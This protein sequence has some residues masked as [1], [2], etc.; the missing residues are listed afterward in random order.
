MLLVWCPGAFA[1]DPSLDISQYAHKAWTIREG[2]FKGL[3]SSVAQ[4]PDG[5]FWLGTD[6]GVFRFDGVKTAAFELPPNQQLPSNAIW[7]LLAD[8]DGTLWIGTAKGLASWKGGKLIRY[9]ELD[10]L[11]VNLLYQDREGAVWASGLGPRG[12]LCRIQTDN[13]Q[14]SGEDGSLGHGVFGLFEDSK[15]DFWTSVVNGVWHWKPGPPQFHP[16]PGSIDSIHSFSESQDSSLLIGTGNGIQRLV[17]GKPSSYPI[18]GFSGNLDVIT[19]LRDRDGGFW[20]GT[21]N[22]LVHVHQG[23]TDVFK[24]SDGLSDDFV[25]GL[26]EDREGNIWVN[27]NGGLDRFRGLTVSTFSVKQGLSNTIVQSVLGGRDGGVWLSTND[28][29]NHWNDGKTTVYRKRAP[30]LRARVAQPLARE[31]LDDGLPDNSIE[32]IFQDDRGRLWVSTL[33]GVAYLEDGRFIPV[34]GVPGGNLPHIIEER[35]GSLWIENQDQGLFHLLDGKVVEQIPWARFGHQDQA[36]ALVSDRARGGLWL[37][38][39][40]GGIAYFADGQLRTSYGTADGLGQGRITHLRL[41]GDGTLWASTG[42]GLSRLKNGSIRTLASTN[43]LPCDTVHWSIEDDARSLWLYMPC[44]LVRIA[45]PELAAWT[46][47]VDKENNANLKI[48]ASVF[49]STDGIRMTTNPGGYAPMVTKSTDGKL[50][51][52]G[53]DGVSVLDPMHLPSTAFHRRC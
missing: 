19:L 47:A 26:F 31:I 43:G 46:A 18:P 33:R 45:R 44:G 49:D 8:R 52:A 13:R 28:G 37:G 53:I 6:F 17:D 29:L 12:R 10:G 36:T 35:S 7:R 4:T 3:V 30:G 48:E 20:I 24:Q 23:R 14:C 9:S 1:L 38:F 34:N 25:R 42:T 5:Y 51:F 16:V 2:F 41:D 15:G 21:R 11:Y 22:G 27:T 40:R 50:W 39:A 32:S